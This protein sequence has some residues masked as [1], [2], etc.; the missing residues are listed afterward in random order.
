MTKRKSAAAAALTSLCLAQGAMAQAQGDSS[1]TLYGRLDIAYDYVHFS[2]NGTTPASSASGIESDVSWWG[3]RGSEDLGGGTR[4][5]FKLESWFNVNNGALFQPGTLFSREAYVGLASDTAGTLQLG[6]QYSPALWLSLNV[7]PFQR[8]GNGAIF[9]LLQ[10]TPGNA[11]G[12]LSVVN[13]AVQYVSPSV[14]GLSARVMYG[15]SN[16]TD[17]PRDLGQTIAASAQYIAGSLFVGGSFERQ[18]ASGASLGVAS[19]TASNTTYAIGAAY[20]FGLL[21][22]SGYYLLNTVSQLGNV[23]G[24]MLGA[25][26]PVGLDAVKASYSTRAVAGASATRSSVYALGYYHS[27]SKRTQVYCSIAHVANGDAAA[28]GLWPS[29]PTYGPQGL[30]GDGQAVTSVT[31]GIR[32]AF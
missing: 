17:A 21:R 29:S 6:S 10:Q 23:S 4:A 25:S 26:A 14:H 15:F 16:R 22:V 18:Q 32:H 20:D 19:D 3:L 1:V 7:D 31:A 2:G 30:P 11:R 5:I 8:A 12:F 28:L 9:N 24:Y 13:N 27:L